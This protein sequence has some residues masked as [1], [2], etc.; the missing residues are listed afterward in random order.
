MV[1]DQKVEGGKQGIVKTV[2]EV[3]RLT[4]LSIRTLRYYDEIGLLKPGR[5][6][7]NGY[8]LYDDKALERLQEIMF[9][10]EME[11]PL[12]T[13]RRLVEHPGINKKEIL[14]LQKAVLEKKR[15][16]LNGLIE[17]ID[18][19]K[20]GVNTMSFEAFN[21][22]EIERI[23]AH[24]M[25]EMKPEHLRSV[26]E[27]YGGEEGVRST[28]RRELKNG[29][30]TSNL[31]KLYGGK[32][33]ALQAALTTKGMEE[34]QE[35]QREN[36]ETYRMFAAAM[37]VDDRELREAAVRRLAESNKKIWKIENARYF[38]LQLADTIEGNEA[39]KTATD[40]QYAEGV[41]LYIVAAIREH[42]GVE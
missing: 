11:L 3:S 17:L 36:D 29:E 4:G 31:I 23:V 24:T 26:E 9:L 13:I 41:S 34:M 19:V 15:N 37:E 12:E 27:Q 2:K 5:D 7:E 14:L 38:L 39:L 33:Q 21:D 20:E 1:G 16:R 6:S 28:L 35:Y 30:V 40:K 8:R 22:E 10:K 18:D 25:K 42:Y 32:E